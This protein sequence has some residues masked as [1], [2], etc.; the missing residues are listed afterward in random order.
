VD[1]PVGTGLQ[2]ERL[3]VGVDMARQVEGLPGDTARRVRLPVVTVLPVGVA[4]G[5]LR[6]VGT[7]R[8]KAAGSVRLPAAS[9]LRVEGR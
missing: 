1:L 6:V 8:L 3:R 2:V 4:M 5:R 9:G 7:V